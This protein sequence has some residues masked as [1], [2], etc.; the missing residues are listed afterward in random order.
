MSILLYFILLDTFFEYAVDLTKFFGQDRNGSI[1]TIRQPPP[2]QSDYH[3]ALSAGFIPP[4]LRKEAVTTWS[5]YNR[6][7]Y[8]PRSLHPM[9]AYELNSSLLPFENWTAGKDLYTSLDHQ[10]DLN[11]SIIDGDFRT[12]AEE[13]DAIQGVHVIGGTDDAWGGFGAKY[14]EGLRDEF[15]LKSAIWV[16]GL[17][18]GF[19]KSVCLLGSNDHDLTV[20]ADRAGAGYEGEAV[21]AKS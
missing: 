19:G 6:I 8:H 16:W 21:A 10:E 11:D 13:C 3:L 5:D 17:E 1:T 2:R 18:Q 15:G 12:W 9:N 7:L 4:S 20:V 14:V